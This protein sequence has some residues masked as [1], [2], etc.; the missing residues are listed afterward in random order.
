MIAMVGQRPLIPRHK[1]D[2][3]PQILSRYTRTLVGESVSSARSTR[4]YFPRL[5]PALVANF[6]EGQRPR[7]MADGPDAY[8]NIIRLCPLPMLLLHVNNGEDGEDEGAANIMLRAHPANQRHTNP[9]DTFSPPVLH[10]P[11]I[12]RSGKG[13]SLSEKMAADIKGSFMPVRN[14]RGFL[15]LRRV[16]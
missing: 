15:F 7:T 5:S 13:I 10:H 3:T 6:A 16:H 2:A 11:S 12:S 9:F 4:D 8:R 14:L 1:L